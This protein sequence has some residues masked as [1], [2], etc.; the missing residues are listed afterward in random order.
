MKVGICSVGAE[1]VSGEVADTNATW[2]ARRVHE[3]GVHVSAVLVV[4]DDEREVLDGLAW[5]ARRADVLVI[6]GGLGP[7]ADDL[8]RYAV[9]EFCGADLSRRQELVDHLDAVYGRLE[10]SMP[11]DALRQADIPE[12]AEV[13]SP[14]GTAAGFSI[15]ATHDEH[16]LRLHL[17]PGVPWEYRDLAERVVLPE[18]IDRAG[19]VARIT[20]VLHVAGLGESGVGERLRGI[21]DR[22][23][24]A[25]GK[26]DD[27][28]HG[29]DLAY[30]AN[31]G[32]VLVKVIA[33]GPS[34]PAAHE[35]AAPI[36]DEA[37]DLLG[38][39][40][41]SIDEQR[42]EDVIAR[43]LLDAGATV[44]TVEGFTA[45]R[46][47]AALSSVPGSERYLSG[48]FVAYTPRILTEVAGVDAA[49]IAEHGPVSEP[50]AAAM[51]RHARRH[52][53]ADIGLA[54]SGVTDGADDAKPPV[55]SVIWAIA[56]PGGRVEVERHYIPAADRDTIQVRGGA[57]ALEALRRHLV[58]REEAD[59]DRG[60][61]QVL[62]R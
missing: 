7:T 38:D 53:G 30:L 14:K 9:A 49:T 15:H 59:F 62:G 33:T 29:I 60:S 24:S 20:R 31:A 21:S 12:G 40:V 50:V 47:A 61:G 48:G 22:L 13:H 25:R 11:E 37:A 19:G 17:L 4:G 2:L 16:P 8:T 10:R 3:I 52:F 42:L 46:V 55:G 44:A 35:R 43:L 34:L 27:A 57:F 23:A 32:E 18:L 54:T 41:T 56:M 5:L 36:V 58:R 45:G 51:A 39:A 1:L 28:E 26:P 6:G